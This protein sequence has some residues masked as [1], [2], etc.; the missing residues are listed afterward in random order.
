[1]AGSAW[2]GTKGNDLWEGRSMIVWL[3]EILS[4]GNWLKHQ[5]IDKPAASKLPAFDEF[6][7][8]LPVGKERIREGKRKLLRNSLQRRYREL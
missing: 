1:M 8:S 6:S 2:F 7:Q 4:V 5:K 3:P